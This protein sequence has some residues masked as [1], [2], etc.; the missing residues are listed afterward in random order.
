MRFI[1]AHASHSHWATAL[2][3]ALAQVA[4]A[5]AQP[6]TI[7]RPNLGIVYFTD[8]YASAAEQLL[9]ELRS[10]TG[11]A[12]WVGGVGV[13]IAADAQEYFDQPALALMLLQVPARDFRVFSGLK[14]LQPA[15]SGW[16]GA[17][18][19]LVHGDP[20]AP[21]MDDLVRD[22]AR[23][24]AAGHVFGGLVSSR[25]QA[26]Q[27][28]D[29]VLHGG[30]SGVAFSARVAMAGGLTQGCE[31]VGPARAITRCT[32]NVIYTLDGEPALSALLEDLG[33]PRLE[34]PRLAPRL[35]ATLAGLSH[36]SG[37]AQS[38]RPIGAETTL[39]HV[40]G[41]DPTGHGV[42]IATALEPGMCVRFCRRDVNAA[43]R[44]LIRLCAEVREELEQRREARQAATQQTAGFAGPPL[45]SVPARGAVY[46]SCAGR[47]GA[48]FGGPSAELALVRKHLG[49]IPL[50]GFFAAGEIA[51]D[52]LYSYTG[53]LTVF[54]EDPVM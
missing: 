32:Q 22:M 3:R 28:A 8:A 16:R 7:A 12:H 11:V 39:R 1:S 50:V 34:L 43:R 30:V 5:R 48:H 4:A 49:D 40:V 13:G 31:P 26:T 37:G 10:R 23:R 20:A 27:I 14:P 24:T 52:R 2:E 15:A 36:A 44:D 9:R 47:G 35:R 54:G 51:G 29:D 45:T 53:V 19:A 46:V 42:A 21:E 17:H 25:T 18:T 6:D 41:L 33:E 38:G